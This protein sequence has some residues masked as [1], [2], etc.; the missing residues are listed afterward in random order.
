MCIVEYHKTRRP[1]DQS[2]QVVG[3]ER[4][5]CSKQHYKPKAMPVSTYY[6]NTSVFKKDCATVRLGVLTEGRV[7]TCLSQL[8]L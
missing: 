1:G 7:S 8:G 3:T 4:L 5:Q 2:Y 6:T